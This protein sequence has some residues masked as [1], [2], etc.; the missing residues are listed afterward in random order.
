MVLHVELQ[1]P[2][3]LGHMVVQLGTE[4]KLVPTLGTDHCL[5]KKKENSRVIMCKSLAFLATVT[6]F[7]MMTLYDILSDF[8]P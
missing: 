6:N 7:G 2:L 5:L 8:K 4:G 1:I 3:M